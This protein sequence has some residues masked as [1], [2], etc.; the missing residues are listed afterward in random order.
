ML[1]NT[2]SLSISAKHSKNEVLTDSMW[3]VIVFNSVSKIINPM[4]VALPIPNVKL[5]DPAMF[6]SS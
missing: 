6:F 5:A 1:K 3:N 4:D 2:S